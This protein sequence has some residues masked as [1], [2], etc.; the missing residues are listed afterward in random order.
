MRTMHIGPMIRAHQKLLTNSFAKKKCL[1][2][3]KDVLS[4]FVTET[5]AVLVAVYLINK[6]AFKSWKY[7]F[8]TG[9]ETPYVSYI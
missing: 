1:H 4:T 5:S 8:T 2:L 6:L 9:S 3:E 7:I